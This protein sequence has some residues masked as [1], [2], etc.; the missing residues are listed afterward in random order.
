MTRSYRNAADGQTVAL[1]VIGWI[2]SDQ[3]RAERFL[4]L[5]GLDASELRAGLGDPA[6]LAAA[7]DFLL[8][9]EPDLIACAEAIGE[10]PETIV[11]V[12]QE[13]G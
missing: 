1:H 5:T 8:T 4:G 10:S 9:H 13:I 12:R 11:A 3:G 7:L 6:I 2:V